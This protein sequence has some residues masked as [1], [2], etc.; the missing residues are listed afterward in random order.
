MGVDYVPWAGRE[1]YIIGSCV[2]Q[3]PSTIFLISAPK[4]GDGGKKHGTIFREGEIM[5]FT[6]RWFVSRLSPGE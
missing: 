6:R 2:T 3:I 4:G 1:R 5:G